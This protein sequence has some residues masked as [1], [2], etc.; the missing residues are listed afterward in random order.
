MPWMETCQMDERVKFIAEYLRQELPLTELCSGFGIS[1]KTVP[2]GV[3]TGWSERRW[4]RRRGPEGDPPSFAD[5]TTLRVAEPNRT[6]C[7]AVEGESWSAREG[8]QT[9]GA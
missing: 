5:S 4:S 2:K 9:W 8:D 3:G 7:E 6:G 1:R